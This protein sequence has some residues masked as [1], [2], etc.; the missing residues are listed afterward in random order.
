MVLFEGTLGV[1]IA[2]L[3]AVALAEA[4]KVRQQYAKAF[5]WLTVSG[6]LFLAANVFTLPAVFAVTS[7]VNAYL[8][9]LFSA[10]AKIAVGVSAIY[11]AIG[12]LGVKKKTKK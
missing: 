12:L 10:L 11:L 3:L 9:Q 5:N 7:Q 2:L 1:G 6:V 4:A 8:T